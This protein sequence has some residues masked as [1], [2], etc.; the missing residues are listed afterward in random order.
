MQRAFVLCAVVALSECFFQETLE[1]QGLWEEYRLKYPYNP[2]VVFDTGSSNLWIPSIYCNSAACNNH[3][4]FNPRT[5]STF[6]NNG[7][8]LRIQYGTGSMT[9]ILGY[10]TVTVGGLAVKNQ[11]IGLSETE[12][13]F[14]QY[15]RADGIL[16]LAYPRLAA[17]GATPVFDNMMSENLVNQDIFSV[18]LSSDTQQSSVVTFGG[19][20]TNH[21]SGSISWIPLSRELYWQ[22][23]VDS[24]TVNGEVVAC[25]GGCQAIVDT[26]TSLIVGPQSSISNI[27]SRVGATN[28]NGDV[29]SNLWILGDV[30]IRQYYAIFSRAKNMVVDSQA[31]KMQRAFVCVPWWRCPSASSTRETLEEQGLWEEYRLKYPYNP[32]VKF[33]DNFAVVF[34][35]GSSNLWIPSIYCNSA[36]CNNHDKFNPRTSSTFRNNGHSLRIQYGTGSMTGILGYDT[37][38][39]QIIGLSETEAPFMQYMRADGILGLAYPRRLHPA[40]LP[41]TQQSSV[42]TFGGIDTNHYSGSISWIPLSRELYWQITV[43]SVTVNGEVVACNGGCQAIVDTGTSLIV[44]P[45][46][47][48]SN[49]NSRVGATNNNGDVSAQMLK[50]IP[51]LLVVERTYMV[52]CN[53][54]AQLPEEATCGSWETSSSDSTTPSSADPRTWWVWP[55]LDKKPGV[56]PTNIFK[57]ITSVVYVDS[58]AVKMQRAF[59]LCAVMALSECLFQS[60][61]TPDPPTCG[62]PPFTA[63]ASPATSIVTLFVLH[64]FFIDNHDKFN[65]GNSSTFRNNGHSLSIQYGTGSMTGFL[66]Y[67]TVT[68]GSVLTFGGVD[69]NHYSGSISWIPLSHDLYW[70]ITVDSVTV[71]GEVVACDGG[72]QAIIDTGTSLI[73]GSQCNNIN[74][75]VGATN[76]NGDNGSKKHVTLSSI[77]LLLQYM[78]DCNSI[79]QLPDSNG[80]RTGFINGGGN[81]WILG[82][83]FIRQYYAIFNRAQNMVGLATAR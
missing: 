42:V 12:A 30:F 13:P 47:S 48:I 4:K 67:D 24:V 21:Y 38:T 75:R 56:N 49:I 19:I 57:S 61:S 5:S 74:N 34:D 72:C 36:A 81:L 64:R 22:I 70:Q 66:G 25:N 63:T 50:D 15:M 28:N 80:C 18:Y 51:A 40:L 62:F 82:D 77:F 71:N 54:I 39:N 7:H 20:D 46:S 3:D 65:P 17:S 27:N 32:M 53:S 73:I 26:G 23:T 76:N 83:V 14:M 10:D 44:G 41:D 35:T 78:V 58:Q 69:P 79:A 8:S 6:R 1:E 37:V 11:I 52:N 60:S 45:Q 43:D 16:G 9:G 2:M 33:D 59:V 68:K 29:R 55:R 31:V